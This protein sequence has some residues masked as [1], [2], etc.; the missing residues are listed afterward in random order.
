[1]ALRGLD[2]EEA[3]R[4]LAR[5][6]P[7][8]LPAPRGR[9]L[10]RF[11]AE[12]LEE[13]IF[14]LLVGA[15]VLYL[16]IGDAAE[17]ILM[18]GCA[19]VSVALVAVQSWR[20]EKV[21]A[22]LKGIVAPRAL[23]VRGGATR[24]VGAETIVPGDLMVLAPGDRVPADGI[25]REGAG[26]VLEESALTGES[27]PV[28]K[29]ASGQAPGDDMAPGGDDTPFV[30]SGTLVLAGEG[31]A[32]ATATGPRS[33][34]GAIGAALATLRWPPTPLQLATARLVRRLALAGVALSI[35]VGALHYARLGDWLE[36][37]L[38]GITL[39]MSAMPEELPMVLAIFLA[40]GAW[41]L[42]RHGVLARQ[43]SAVLALGAT[44]VLCVD[45]TGTITENRIRLERL[46]VDGTDASVDEALGDRRFDALR[47]AS[48]RASH[49]QG[50]DPMDRATLVL[51]PATLDAALREYP[52]ESGRPR[53]A[54]AWRDGAE[55]LV[56]AKGAPEEI[57]RL[58]RL[59][60]ATARE[61]MA[62]VEAFAAEG[63]RVL[64][65][66]TAR[67]PSAPEAIDGLAFAW[68]GLLAYGDPVRDSARVSVEE[69]LAAGIEVVMITGD[70]PATA[71]AVARHAGIDAQ[72]HAM[73]GAEVAR[74]DD[75]ALREAVAG[76]RVFARTEPGQKLRIVEA[77]RARG[78]VVAMTGDGVNDAP[79]L[80]AA[81]VGVAMGSRGTDV[82]REAAGLVVLNDDL[83]S[84]VAAIRL[85]RRIADNI[86]KAMVFVVAVH[87]PLVGLALLPLLFGWPPM[88]APV[89]VIFLEL[90]IDPTCAIVFEAQEA[91]RRAMRRPP[92]PA[93]RTVAS[94]LTISLAIAQG[95]ALLACAMTAY[96]VALQLGLPQREARALGFVA[97]VAGTL[98]LAL[99]NLSWDDFAFAPRLL[100]HPSVAV[101]AGATSAMLALLLAWP[102]ARGVF[103]LEVPGAAGIALAIGAGAASVLWFEAVKR[104]GLLARGA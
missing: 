99:T 67:A 34:V 22:A 36:A 19:A 74:M 5:V 79:A 97:L 33:R 85:G 31:I 8:A 77:L 25:L 11:F 7:N 92:R 35:L 75:A 43:P 4:R 95:C 17:G 62:R 26:L 13:P 3:A 1:M 60:G 40:M 51:G 48:L 27:V 72:G 100:S 69:C 81:H 23:V 39:A 16:A 87:V 2:E 10:L 93:G 58:C 90:V 28:R 53:V 83:G 68:A 78:H 73:S 82:A 44:T 103:A 30:F 49:P 65:V 66:A 15:A 56:A 89:H 101:A 24:R 18:A 57:A 38:A 61:A 52:I 104:G 70:Y 21:L 29:R 9:G 94:P 96:G 32:E 14:L 37:T 71:C 54:L 64:A 80:R 84:I 20:S 41:R 88:L 50:G 45:K 47:A 6:G 91:E 59:D 76:K 46:A 98:C 86:R 55:I 42:S 102:A 63:L 12:V